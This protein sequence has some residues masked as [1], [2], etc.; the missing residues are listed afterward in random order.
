MQPMTMRTELRYIYIY[1]RLKSAEKSA[2][3]QQGGSRDWV[4]RQGVGWRELEIWP[5]WGYYRNAIYSEGFQ[6]PVVLPLEVG[7]FGRGM[8]GST[9]WGMVTGSCGQ[10]V[11][12]WWLHLWGLERASWG[13]VYIQSG[14]KVACIHK[15]Y[16]RSMSSD[17]VYIMWC[18]YL[19]I[20]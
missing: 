13:E 12:E 4:G 11:E 6:G 9:Y 5:V 16:R 18:K 2:G 3:R 10:V 20:E 19:Y 14:F 1:M 17:H 7:L 15:W 8:G